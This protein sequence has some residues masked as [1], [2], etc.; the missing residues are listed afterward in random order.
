MTVKRMHE[1]GFREVLGRVISGRY[2]T[3]TSWLYVSSS[4]AFLVVFLFW[5]LS[6]FPGE[7]S[8]F[9]NAVSN[10]GD[11]IMNPWPGWAIFTAGICAFGCLM[12]PHAI[13]SY[14]RIA[15]F[16][17]GW[18]RSFLVASVIGNAGYAGVGLFSE[19]PSTIVPHAIAAAMAFGGLISA[20]A[21]SWSPAVARVKRT[22]SNHARPGLIAALTIIVILP[23]VCFSMASLSA[24][25]SAMRGYM[26]PGLLSMQFWEWMLVGSLAAHT[27]LLTTLVNIGCET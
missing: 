11:P 3:R 27:F 10:L 15:T 21:L 14:R 24:F 23:V 13:Y 16:K 4:Y 20:A 12:L 7:Y 18:A 26:D 2:S 25:I 1:D 22:T 6:F 5:S 8:V 19:A 17:P 9:A